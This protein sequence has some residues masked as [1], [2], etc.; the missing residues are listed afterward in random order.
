[1][2]EPMTQRRLG[3]DTGYSGLAG[4]A[5][6]AYGQAMALRD[7]QAR[8]DAA[9]TASMQAATDAMSTPDAHSPTQLPAHLQDVERQDPS[10]GRWLARQFAPAAS[11]AEADAQAATDRQGSTGSGGRRLGW[12]LGH[13]DDAMG[14]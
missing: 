11:G 5:S 14:R 13:I 3:M 10:F 8:Q 4:V 9:R 2:P 12:W 1:M 6:D 7:Q